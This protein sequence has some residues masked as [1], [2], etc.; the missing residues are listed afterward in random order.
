LAEERKQ[1]PKG[2]NRRIKEQRQRKKS[3]KTN[4]RQWEPK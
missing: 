2:S 4:R 1:N 3:M